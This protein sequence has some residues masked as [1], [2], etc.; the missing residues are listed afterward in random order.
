MSDHR[1]PTILDTQRE[2][3]LPSPLQARTSLIY[4]TATKG[5]TLIGIVPRPASGTGKGVQPVQGDSLSGPY[6]KL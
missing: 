1:R 6:M 2:G 4:A 5:E 3:V